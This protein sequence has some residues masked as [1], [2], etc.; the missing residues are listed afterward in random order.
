MKNLRYALLLVVG[1]G[2][3]ASLATMALVR[4]PRGR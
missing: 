2:L 4:R 3:V 1:A